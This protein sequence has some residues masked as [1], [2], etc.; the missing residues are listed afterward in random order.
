M[1][2]K[3]FITDRVT[4]LTMEYEKLVVYHLLKDGRLSMREISRRI[5]ISH[6]TT[7][8]YFKKLSE[9]G[10]IGPFY[11]YVNPNLFGFYHSFVVFKGDVIYEI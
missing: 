4:D 9:E 3:R 10:V 6:T 7:L 2:A 11:L 1:K 5:G 8:Y